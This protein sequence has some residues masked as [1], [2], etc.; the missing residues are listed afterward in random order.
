LSSG[1]RERRSHGLRDLEDLVAVAERGRVCL[2][3]HGH[4]HGAYHHPRPK[5]A[6]FPVICAG[7]A[8]QSGLWSYGDYTITDRLFRAVW[9]V[10]DPQTGGFRDGEAFD[11]E[12]RG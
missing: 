3:L 8:T 2:W 5:Q 1:K 10:F 4:R 11:L 12:W 7:S 6:P 9:R